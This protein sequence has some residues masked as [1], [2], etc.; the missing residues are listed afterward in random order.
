[1][2]KRGL[3]THK[4]TTALVRQCC[5]QFTFVNHSFIIAL[6][7]KPL[8]PGCSIG[9]KR[10]RNRSDLLPCRLHERL[11][12]LYPWL[13]CFHRWQVRICKSF[14]RANGTDLA[15]AHLTDASYYEHVLPLGSRFPYADKQSAMCRQSL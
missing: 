12:M 6:S 8:V 11:R 14:K 15:L 7:K 4:H 3:T 5:Q 10:P 9:E 1:M 2:V 13:H